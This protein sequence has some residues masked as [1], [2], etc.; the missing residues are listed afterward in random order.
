[1]LLQRLKEYADQRMHLPPVLYTETPVRY[2]IELNAEGQLLSPRPTDTADNSSP[3]TKRGQRRLVPQIQRTVGIKPLLLADK[4]DYTLG[5]GSQDAKPE[6]IAACHTAYLELLT[7]CAE[8]TQSAEVAAVLRFL[9]NTPTELLELPDGFDRGAL[10]TF[11]VDDTFVVDLPAVRAF[12]A[13]Q[14]APDGVLW[15]RS[16]TD[17]ANLRRLRRAFHQGR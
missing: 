2:I 10:V 8:Q 3:K 4:A 9:Q 15:P 12:W 5:I 14:H 11:R 1:M 16:F 13:A 7:R 17:R 6:R